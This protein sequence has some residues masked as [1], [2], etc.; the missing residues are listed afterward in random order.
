MLWQTVQRFPA[1]NG[2]FYFG[3]FVY[4]LDQP[5]EGSGSEGLFHTEWNNRFIQQHID[6]GMLPWLLE[7]ANDA[8]MF[9]SLLA[10]TDAA[11]V[12]RVCQILNNALWAMMTYLEES[13]HS[14]HGE[15]HPQLQ[16]AFD[17]VAARIEALQP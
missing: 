1:R 2:G 11:S 6:F 4:N 8:E 9:A 16:A 3:F 12:V 13:N 15:F 7:F 5:T 10:A 17:S 14:L